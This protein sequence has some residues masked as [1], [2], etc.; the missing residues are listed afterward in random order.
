MNRTYR[1]GLVI[2]VAGWLVLLL[3]LAAGLSRQG[4]GAAAAEQP[5]IIFIMVDALRADHISANGYGR[6]TTPN[7]DAWVATPGATFT[8]ATSASAWTF[9]ANAAMLTGRMPSSLGITFG[10]DGSRL[11][12]D[13]TLLAEH[14]RAAGYV[15]AGFVS[16]YYVWARFGFDQGFDT[17]AHTT[18]DDRADEVNQLARSWLDTH[19]AGESRTEP[20][21]LYLYYFDPHTH[22]DPPPPYDTL[23]DSDYTGP[24]TGE[25][26]GHGEPVVSGEIV[27]T[28]RDVEHL[29]ALYDGEIA[30]WDAQLGEMLTYLQGL[31]LL[32]N[33]I[34]VVSSDHGQMFGEH[35]RW[36]HRNSLYEEVLRVPL[37]LRFD[38]VV[39]GDTAVSAPVHAIDITPTLLDMLGLPLPAKLQG[40]SLL[41]LLQG[42][43][44]SGDRPIYS[45]LDAVTDPAHSA[46]WI[47]PKA[48][49]YALKQAGWKYVHAAGLR[50][51]DLLLE[52]GE[53]SVYE[54]D[55]RLGAEPARADALYTQLHEAFGLPSRFQFL[56]LV[57]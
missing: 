31:G 35:D 4:G 18:G 52:V 9:P 28:P 43:P 8:D 53:T 48:N 38:G 50:E 36:I 55:N 54:G 7:L 29:I 13:E 42:A 24:L 2:G 34:I 16:S 56:P 30:Y 46:Y 5:N 20:L 6:D 25:A 12:A 21:F 41:P 3:V 32:E 44:A 10:S 14:L 45:E 57:D 37:L 39:P 23:Y 1:V 19:W 22:Y 26:Y 47:A 40:M 15:T 33:S 17:Y 49:L 51:G 11:P 27:P